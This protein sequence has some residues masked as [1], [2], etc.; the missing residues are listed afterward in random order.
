LVRSLSGVAKL[1]PSLTVPNG[2]LSLLER[3]TDRR[4]IQYAEKLFD[5]LMLVWP[6]GLN[7]LG[8]ERPRLLQRFA[9][10]FVGVAHTCNLK[11][12]AVNPGE[13]DWFSHY[14]GECGQPIISANS[15]KKRCAS[16]TGDRFVPLWRK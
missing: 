16:P 11:A 9:N 8:K 12:R 4:V 13:T 10:S 15:E 14:R 2:L 3:L 6:V 5:S 1:L 7:V